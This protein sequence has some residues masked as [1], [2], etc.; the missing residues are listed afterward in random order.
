MVEVGVGSGGWWYGVA[1]EV[2][3]RDRVEERYDWERVHLLFL[4]FVHR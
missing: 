3:G 4:K 2:D 1:G